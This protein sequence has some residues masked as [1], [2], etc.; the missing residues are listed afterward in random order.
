[1]WESC[2]VSGAAWPI[3]T[4]A[5]SAAKLGALIVRR[6]AAARAEQAGSERRSVREE[7]VTSGSFSVWGERK[8][9]VCLCG[10]HGLRIRLSIRRPICP[11]QRL[12]VLAGNKQILCLAQRRGT[13]GQRFDALPDR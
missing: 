3:R 10:K 6:T 12:I 8:T 9:G 7:E 13:A 1:M 11:V 2:P 5:G 4:T